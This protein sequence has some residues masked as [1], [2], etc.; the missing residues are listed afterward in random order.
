[1]RNYGIKVLAGQEKQ[2]FAAKDAKVVNLKQNVTIHHE[3]HEEHE[4]GI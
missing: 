1:M 4:D 3:A 2:S